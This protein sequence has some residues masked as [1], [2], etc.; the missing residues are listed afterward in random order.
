MRILLVL[1]ILFGL[2]S[3]TASATEDKLTVGISLHP[4]YAYVAN[5][6]GDKGDVLPLIETGFNP[7]NYSLSPAD[8][9]RLKKMDA[10]VV[11]GIGHD[12]F[13]VKA[14]KQLN[15]QGLTVI[16][17]NKGIALLGHG[18][19][20]NPHTF[21]SIDAAIRQ[22]YTIAK[23]LGKL[24]PESAQYFAKNAFNYAKKLRKLK[25]P[26]Q[27]VLIDK[28]LSQVKIASTHN[29]Y[30]Y[31]LQEFGLTVSAVVE[32]AHGISPSAAQLKKTIDKINQANIDVLFTE[33]NMAN[34]YVELIEKE[35]G[36]KVYHFS[37]MTHGEY[38]VGMVE[39]EM[40]HNL[41]KL[42]EALTFAATKTGGA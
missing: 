40:Q 26:V 42:T 9:A 15:P 27:N 1:V 24:R 20:H 11:N 21:I 19:K 13:A 22:V 41:D 18:N 3:S 31:L 16:N 14:I 35:T 36:I 25:K 29:A 5:V 4:Y 10:M 23:A 28:D 8:I 2:F 6:L 32:P 39:K 33:L 38:D 37:H 17:A 7:H 30:G 34:E 12:E